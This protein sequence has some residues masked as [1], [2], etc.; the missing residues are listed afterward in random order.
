LGADAPGEIT[1]FGSLPGPRA[2]AEE[3]LGLAR[4]VRADVDAF[5]LFQSLNA[6]QGSGPAEVV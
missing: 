4:Y 5:S 3:A 6:G 2:N 1:A